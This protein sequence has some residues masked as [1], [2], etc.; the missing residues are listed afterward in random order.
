[1]YQTNSQLTTIPLKARYFFDLH[2]DPPYFKWIGSSVDLFPLS[3]CLSFYLLSHNSQIDSQLESLNTGKSLRCKTKGTLSLR[4]V[5]ATKTITFES[6]TTSPEQD[7]LSFLL[8][9]ASKLILANGLFGAFQLS[10]PSRLADSTLTT[11]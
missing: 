7:L 5:L 2:D 9:A 8:Y 3:F 11:R 1:M 6:L 10:F 4:V